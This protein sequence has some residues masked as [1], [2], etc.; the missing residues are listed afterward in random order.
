MRTH[1]LNQLAI[2]G[3]EKALALEPDFD[4]YRADKVLSL[5]MAFARRNQALPSL[6]LKLEYEASSR[7]YELVVLLED[8]RE[9]VMPTIAPGL[10]LPELEIEDLRGRGMEGASFEVISHFERAFRC[11]CGGVSIVC[12]EP[13][14]AAAREL[15]TTRS[16][17][18]EMVPPSTRLEMIV[19][20]DDTAGWIWSVRVDD[21][22]LYGTA[23]LH[24]EDLGAALFSIQRDESRSNPY[25]RG[26]ADEEV[27]AVL[28]GFFFGALRD[29][30]RASAEEQ[31]WAKHLVSPALP[32][33]VSSRLYLVG[34][35]AGRERLLASHHEGMRAFQLA[36]GAFDRELTKVRNVLD[37]TG[38]DAF[39]T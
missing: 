39:R 14:E 11:T 24:R 36:E 23:R 28:D 16:R 32:T 6:W 38:L 26:L 15:A 30:L 7:S 4:F 17:G 25:L 10:V 20:G 18:R 3:R 2:N 19:A 29:A 31:T 34:S 13:Q 5:E 21:T 35:G 37:A 22:V 9:L 12:F 33:V 8:V 1:F 27:F